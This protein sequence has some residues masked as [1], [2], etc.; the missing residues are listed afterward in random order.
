MCGIIACIGKQA[1]YPL[2]KR[3]L[4]ALEYRG[5]DSAGIA[6]LDKQL[7]IEKIKGRVEKLP[8]SLLTGTIG[9]GHTRWATHGEPSEVNAHPHIV[10]KIALV[11]NGIIENYLELKEKYGFLATSQTDSEI[12]AHLINE[13]YSTDLL[14]AVMKATALCKGTYAIAVLHEESKEIVV[15]RNGSPLLIGLGDGEY[16]VS[17]DVSGVIE[18]TNKVVYLDDLEYARLSFTGAQFFDCRG[19]KIT[20][21]ETLVNWDVESVQKGGYQHYMLKEIH[22]QPDVVKQCLNM[23]IKPLEKPQRLLLIGCGTASYAGLVAK[24]LIEEHC[25]LSC[26]WEQASEF[27]YKENCLKEGDLVVVI[28]QS[29]ETAD[30]LAA[31]RLAK[32][33][34]IPTLGIVNVVGSTIARECDSVIYTPIGPE[35]GVASTKAFLAQLCIFYRL[36]EKWGASFPDLKKI[37]ILLERI[38]QDDSVKKIAERY[39]KS[40]D[41]LYIGRKYSYPIALEGALKLKEI[42]YI[43]AEG[44]P[45]GEMK[46]GPIALVTD[47]VPVVALCPQDSVY[48]KMISNIQEVRARRGRIIAIA[49]EGD[50]RIKEHA[51]DVLFIPAV[52][53]ALTP[54]LSVVPLQLLAYHIALLKECDIDKPRNLAKSVTV[55]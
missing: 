27:R 3:G 14:H 44:Y 38:I 51:H 6:I 31:L 2:L 47:R 55:E 5:Y 23:D 9:I 28:S 16:F 8:D 46:H 42:S 34:K 49:T 37:P 19:N 39:F 10:G 45:A 15:A 4:Q 32:E 29:G 17:S 22:E 12:L 54:L 21:E 26:Y 36:A 7:H 13:F 48:D 50:E 11:H 20:K 53:E 40:H 33:N 1:V 43:H 35:I 18:H 52:E 41:A 30:T 25:K 24:Y